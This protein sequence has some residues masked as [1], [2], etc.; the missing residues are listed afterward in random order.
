MVTLKK[1]T[2][3][4]HEITNKKGVTTVAA[5]SESEV[6]GY[7]PIDYL[8][9]A[10]SI[11]MGLTLDALINR[12]GLPIKSYEIS[13]D[14]TKAEGRPSRLEKL[15]VEITFDRKLEKDVQEKL[16]KSAKRGCTIGNTIEHGAAVNVTVKE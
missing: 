3:Q 13:V 4:P 15:D 8:T 6:D 16:I 10:V 11:C 2:D 14:A 5:A 7:S 9:S 1:T 12:D